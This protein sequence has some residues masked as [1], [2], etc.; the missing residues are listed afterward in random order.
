M[1]KNLLVLVMF[2]FIA[3][4]QNTFAQTGKIQSVDTVVEAG[5]ICSGSTPLSCVPYFSEVM[6]ELEDKCMNDGSSIA[7][8]VK[9]NIQ[10]SE[11]YV[12]CSIIASAVCK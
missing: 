10:C 12:K 5:R 7:S 6:I 9:S 8:D 3:T 4:I 11:D 2:L 1:I